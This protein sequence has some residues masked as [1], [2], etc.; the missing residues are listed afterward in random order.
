MSSSTVTTTSSKLISQA[1]RTRRGKNGISPKLD[2]IP[3]LA[4]FV[5]RRTVLHQ[6]RHFLKALTKLSGQDRTM[7]VSEVQSNFRR[8]Q[9]ETDPLTIQM[10]MKE[11]ERRLAQV[12]ALVGHTPAAFQDSDSWMNT[13]DVEDPRGRVGT[14]WP[15]QQ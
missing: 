12:Q 14:T 15:W 13:P 10:A 2:N 7:A 1:V 3:T 8:V 6:Y 4:E 5:H 9:Y 11:G